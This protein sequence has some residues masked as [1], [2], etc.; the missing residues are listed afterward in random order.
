MNGRA[1]LLALA[2]LWTLLLAGCSSARPWINAPLQGEAP[3]AAEAWA[4][5]GR[6]PS[7]LMAVMFSGGGARAAAF[8]YGVLSELQQS[9]VHVAGR[10]T[11]LLAEVDL[12]G[13][14]SG[15]SI[16]AAYLSTFGSAGLARFEEDYLRQNFQDS[17]IS[18]A[19]RPGNLVALTSP[20]FG[21]SHLLAERLD[22]LYQGATFGDLARRPGHP[23]LLIT[24]TDMSLGTGFEFTRD[25]FDLICS[26][27][28]SVPVSFAV[29]ASSAVPILLSP[30]TL[31]NYAGTCQPPGVQ[32][33]TWSDYRARL[34]REQARSYLDVKNRPYI[35]LVDGGLSDNL[36]VRRL[37]DNAL[38]GG[39]LRSALRR[40]GVL[41]G[42]IRKLVLISVN[43]ERD[44][45]SNIDM[46][47]RLPGMAQVLDTLLFGAGARATKET[48]EFLAD[49]TRQWRAEVMQRHDGREDVFAPEAQVHVIQVNLRDAPESLRRRELMQ[50]PTAFSISQQDVTQLIEAGRTILRESPEFKALM[51]SLEQ[52]AR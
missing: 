44:P 13:G 39:G 45:S 52:D 14:V 43:S 46:S 49:V 24:A 16:M 38:A 6:D 31:R 35:H 51:R 2:M 41:P 15:G 33:E 36:G 3:P 26:D 7:I 1:G 4:D 18:H 12:A 25:Q 22:T 32:D 17:L 11:D 37:L 27:L 30:V 34:Y 29:T 28:S 20:W 10:D 19:M 5:G 8:G 48:Q 42:T 23:E 50:V 47:D 21:R 9:R 40:S